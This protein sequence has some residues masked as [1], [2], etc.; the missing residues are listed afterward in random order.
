LPEDALKL[1]FLVGKGS[2]TLLGF[3]MNAGYRHPIKTTNE[4]ARISY[5]ER[6]AELATP[7]SPFAHGPEADRDQARLDNVVVAP[8][9]TIVVF[10]LAPQFGCLWLV[11]TPKAAK[12]PWF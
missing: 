11:K 6:Q 5:E 3:A 1:K 4:L 7:A 2:V 10:H 12:S 8:K 9:A